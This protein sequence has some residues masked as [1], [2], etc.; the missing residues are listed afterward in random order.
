MP[1]ELFAVAPDGERLVYRVHGTPGPTPLL[2]VHGLVSSVQH[3]PFFT[4]HY[5][6]RRPV[7]SWEY[8]GH[9]G[10]P[11]PHDSSQIGVAQFADD[12]NAVWRAARLPPAIVVGLSFGVQVALELWRR[13]P[14]AVRALVLICGTAGHP[15]DRVS[16]S[17]ALRRAIAQ[18]VRALGQARLAAAPLLALL[19]SRIGAWL[20]REAAFVSGG[21]H[22][23]AC[24][25]EVLD[26][27]F[28]HVGALAPEVIAASIAAYV[29]HDAF[30][31]LPTITVPTLIVA[32]DR[33]QLTPVETAERMQRAIAGSEL[34]V[35]RGHTHLVQVEQ[36]AEVHA[37]IDRFLAAHRL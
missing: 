37:A 23:D 36:P 21:A 34:V 14:E 11:P 7:L 19:R 3:W 30:D 8:R 4:A 5:A 24:P 6:A 17:P 32:G 1:P 33:D 18:V 28:A 31:V 12:A 29:E 26:E 16:S 9:G 27:L 25:R 22:R 20:A 2:T 10:Q 15:L 35:F 13:R